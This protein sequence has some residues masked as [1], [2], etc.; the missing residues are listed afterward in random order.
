MTDE[1]IVVLL[2]EWEA[3]KALAPT[4]YEGVCDAINS[5]CAKAEITKI[6][7]Q[8]RLNHMLHGEDE[9]QWA[10]KFIKLFVKYGESTVLRILKNGH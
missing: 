3:I 1:D 4:R 2:G 6:V 8:L 5:E 9:Q 10:D 7:N